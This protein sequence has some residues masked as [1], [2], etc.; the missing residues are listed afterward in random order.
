MA[1]AVLS[2]SSL[3]WVG[4]RLVNQDRVF[5][6]R[7]L[8][9][10]REAAADRLTA[11]LEQILSAEERRLADLPSVDS[12]PSADDVVWILIDDSKARFWPD[13]A[14]LFYPEIPPDRE[15]PAHLYAKAEK[16]EFVDKD[17]SRAA[18]ELRPLTRSED[19][20]VRI[21]AGLRLARNLRKAGT[22]ESALDISAG[23]AEGPDHGITV[24]GV[25]ADLV[26]HRARCSLL[27]ELGRTEELRQ[28]AQSILDGLREKRWRLDRASYLYYHDQSSRCLDREPEFDTEQQALAE[29]TS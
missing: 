9:E 14:L 16:S 27:E 11:S 29:A 24:S 8:E 1:V 6:A 25:P 21:G 26:A 2:V 18:H 10:R 28:Q 20:A 19:Q 4:V 13:N 5:E 12:L 23:L 22:L 7:Q 15:P 17:F 3:V